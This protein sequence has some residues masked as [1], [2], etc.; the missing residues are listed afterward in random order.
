[1]GSLTTVCS[2]HWLAVVGEMTV[3]NLQ[4]SVTPG[5]KVKTN[6]SKTAS[7]DFTISGLVIGVVALVDGVLEDADVPSVLEVCVPRETSGVT[8]RYFALVYEQVQR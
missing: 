7:K 6:S 1:M 2:L 8:G 3:K 5:Y 4:A